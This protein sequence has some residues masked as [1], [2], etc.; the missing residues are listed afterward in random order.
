MEQKKKSFK[1]KFEH[2]KD[3]AINTAKKVGVTIA[4]HPLETIA[5]VAGVTG[6]A[7]SVAKEV[8]L[9]GERIDEKRAERLYYLPELGVKVELRHPIRNDEALRLDY[10]TSNGM[11]RLEALREMDLLKI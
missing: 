5:V 7:T 9:S 3:G 11:S 2:F 8:R 10:M 4:E 6:I 1:E